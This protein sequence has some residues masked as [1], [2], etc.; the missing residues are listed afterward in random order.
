MKRFSI[1][2]ALFLALS[3]TSCGKDGGERSEPP[4]GKPGTSQGA[5]VGK[6]KPG[7]TSGK[8]VLPE[9]VTKGLP[10]AMVE[11]LVRGKKENRL[12]LVE[13]YDEE[14]NFC[15]D[16]D[17]VLM[18]PEVQKAL[19][20]FIFLKVGKDV[21]RLVEEFALTMTPT[22]LCYKPGGEPMDN[23]LEG[24]RSAKVFPLELKNFLR[25]FQGKPELEVPDDDH[26]NYGKG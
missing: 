23:V 8:V 21:E 26:P 25:S 14:C 9:E 2:I 10:K 19:K 13:V 22:F 1:L 11:A 24:F 18:S 12:V 7:G 16:M 6:K 17:K 5:E 15:V 20:P 4:A 3:L